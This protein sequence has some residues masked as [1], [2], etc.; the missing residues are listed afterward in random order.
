MRK[1]FLSVAVLV[2]IIAAVGCTSTPTQPTTTTTTIL[3][4]EQ[5]ILKNY[6]WYGYFTAD[7]GAVINVD[8]D[9]TA[10]GNVDL[11]LMDSGYF[12]EYQ[13]FVNGTAI[14]FHYYGVG[15][16]LNILSKSYNFTIP[17]YGTYYV[18]VDNVKDNISGEAVPTGAV[19]VKIKITETT[20]N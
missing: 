2:I 13:N 3:D 10:G 9:V 19:T 16:A 12:A 4:Q 1:V 7:A 17:E 8:L 14:V 6:Y 20:T 11:F 18:V 5:T 15:S